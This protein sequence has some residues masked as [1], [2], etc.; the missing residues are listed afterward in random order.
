MLVPSDE[1]FTL[2]KA[3]TDDLNDLANITCGAMPKD[4]QWDY[5]FP[6][7]KKYPEDHWN[8]TRLMLKNPMETTDILINV[9]TVPSKEDGETNGRSIALAVWEL[10]GSKRL[11]TFASGSYNHPH[12]VPVAL[13]DLLLGHE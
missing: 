7:R 12:A 6:H 1:V 9:I 4:L 11:F 13:G 5:C 10:P 2:R 8:G 3:T